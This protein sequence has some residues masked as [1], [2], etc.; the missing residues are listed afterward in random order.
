MMGTLKFWSVIFLF[1]ISTTGFS[2]GLEP[3]AKLSF[4]VV[5]EQG[6]PV[7]NAVVEV[8]FMQPRDAKKGLYE[9]IEKA[10]TDANGR[11]EA[12]HQT[13]G[14][15]AYTVKKDG[16]YESRG[17]YDFV[18]KELLKWQPWNQL[19]HVV[20]RKI[21]N[22]VPM[23]ARNTHQ[24]KEVK[25]PVTVD[26]EKGV[27]FDLIAYDWVTPYGKGVYS[28][29][30]F[31]MTSKYY[32]EHPQYKGQYE[33]DTELTLTFSNKYDGIQVIKDSRKG[34]SVFKLPRFAPEA[35]YSSVLVENATYSFT[36]PSKT[37]FRDDNNFFFR[38]RSEE[39]DGKLYRAMYGKIQGEIKYSPEGP[40]SAVI[41]FKYYLN[42]DYTR[43]MEYD[44]KRN[45]FKDNTG[46]NSVG[47]D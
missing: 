5:D 44:P 36:E 31:K 19:I 37:T 24:S 18:K 7:E 45:L 33:F 34:G 29:F 38:I 3:T 32:K 30:V 27:G 2:W 43:N 47:L 42:P 14:W 6:K 15:A 35:G 10:V 8:G 17:R 13:V 4:E 41:I 26:L 11:C 21:E 1:M 23:Y 39:R 40:N 22:P 12:S 46:L 20:L 9:E 16:Y 25:I 28:D